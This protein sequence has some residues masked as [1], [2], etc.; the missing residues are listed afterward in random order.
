MKSLQASSSQLTLNS[1]S[2]LEYNN[3]TSDKL[4]L[5]SK[6]SRNQ[7][8]NDNRL[9]KAVKR[10]ASLKARI[11][12]NKKRN[13]RVGDH[14]VQM[15][16]KIDQ[17]KLSRQKLLMRSSRSAWMLKV[18]SKRQGPQL[19]DNPRRPHKMKNNLGGSLDLILRIRRRQNHLLRKS[20]KIKGR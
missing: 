17:R 15:M 2:L 8:S 13:R 1:K 18:P 19:K 9:V 4:N 7:K 16:K 20:G 3:Q 5:C 10:E 6:T 11:N 12:S 14:S